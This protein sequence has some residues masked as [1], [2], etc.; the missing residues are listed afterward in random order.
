MTNVVS[1]SVAG[2]IQAD[3]QHI[4][5]VP[6]PAKISGWES[7]IGQYRASIIG[8]S[9][10]P[11]V[12]FETWLNKKL[13]LETDSCMD[14]FYPLIHFSIQGFIP[15]KDPAIPLENWTMRDVYEQEMKDRKENPDRYRSQF[16]YGYWR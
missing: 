10:E 16:K 2:L 3:H 12:D 11:E 9:M 4:S 8:D 15:N 13:K 5:F 6:S 1:H 7:L 14:R